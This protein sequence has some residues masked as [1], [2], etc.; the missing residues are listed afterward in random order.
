MTYP[1]NFFPLTWVAPRIGYE[2]LIPCNSKGMETPLFHFIHLP[3][4]PWTNPPWFRVDGE[5][6]I[7]LNFFGP[8][9]RLGPKNMQ[10]VSKFCL[11][12]YSKYYCTFMPPFLSPFGQLYIFVASEIFRSVVPHLTVLHKV[13][14]WCISKIFKEFGNHDMSP[15]VKQ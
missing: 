13:S 9:W 7:S 2:I 3:S 14:I 10:S 1:L 12:P 11:V 4:L 8:C 15:F 5:V 6:V